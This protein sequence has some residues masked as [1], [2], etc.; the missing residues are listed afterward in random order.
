VNS[1]D[2]ATERA[3]KSFAG[4]WASRGEPRSRCRFARTSVIFTA[5]APAP[6]PAAGT[7]TLAECIEIALANRPS[8]ESAAAGSRAAPRARAPGVLG[9]SLPQLNGS[10]SSNRRKS[11]F[12]SRTQSASDGSSR[13]LA[14]DHL[15]LPQ[16]RSRSHRPLRLRPEPRRDQASRAREASLRADADTERKQVVYEVKQSY[17]DLLAARRLL[18]V[19]EETVK[20]NRQ[21]LE[22]AR[23]R[24]EVGFAPRIDVTR[25]EVLLARAELDLL[26]ARNNAT[27]A[28]AT[29][30]NALGL[31]GPLDFEIADEL[32]R[33]T[34]A[35]DEASALDAA[36]QSRSGCR[37]AARRSLR[38]RRGRR[39]AS[40][41]AT[42]V[43]A[44]ASYGWSNS[45]FP[46]PTTGVQGQRERA[47]FSGGLTAARVA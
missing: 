45:G 23:G 1:R 8:L 14:V 5:Q 18:A 36:Y 16:Q 10:Y 6:Q 33:K 29:L 17:F 40:A 32:E 47:I 3:V 46:S 19:A 31:D 4:A 21:Q 43:S 20:S 42:T 39:A 9:L 25:S 2:I 13:A 12:S 24:N 7:K 15:Q 28:A 41:R 27:V 34:V 37:A 11:S 22:Q 35:L 38:Q 30:R 44:D 26:A